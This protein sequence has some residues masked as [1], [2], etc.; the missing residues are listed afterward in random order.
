MINKNWQ[1][2]FKGISERPLKINYPKK[3]V[4][5]PKPKHKVSEKK[6]LSLNQLKTVSPIIGKRQS[7]L[8]T[9]TTQSFMLTSKKEWSILK[10]IGNMQKK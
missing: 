9:F 3:T 6:R 10:T 5:E 7:K 4:R 2:K 1:N 8:I